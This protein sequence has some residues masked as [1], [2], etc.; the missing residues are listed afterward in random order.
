MTQ[1]LPTHTSGADAQI[2]VTSPGP[3]RT[4]WRLAPQ[5]LLWAAAVVAGALA[6]PQ[7]PWA[8][9]GLA[10]CLGLFIPFWKSS[11][12]VPPDVSRHQRPGDAARAAPTASNA[13][14]RQVLPVW[15]R[16][17]DSARLH[18]EQS[19][20]A[21]AESF[22]GIAGELD[23]AL[24][25]GGSPLR[26]D[27]RS[28]TQLLDTHR[29]EMD[30]LLAST[31]RIAALKNALA[32]GL[33][34]LS[35]PLSAMARLSKEVQTISRATHLLALNASVEAQ[36]VGA[37]GASGHG[38]A[39]VAQEVRALADQSRQAGAALDKH[40]AYLRDRVADLQQRGQRMDTG[41]D[42][43]QLQAEQAA[44]DVVGALLRSIDEV[45][46]SQRS[47]HDTGVQ[48]QREVEQILVNLQSQDRMSQMLVSVTD[49]MTR[50]QSWLEGHADEAAAA[51]SQ[52]L[53]RLE[54]SYT[55][56]DMRSSHHDTVRV[57]KAAE[58]E[59]F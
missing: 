33:G 54:A 53:E 58:V 18:A 25:D 15:R 7:G 3:R 40:L 10:L 23:R 44:R 30:T 1:S 35:E 43:L 37:A 34:D 9:A 19:I 57:D 52:W 2:G 38:F 29:P 56:E 16:N 12:R 50:M 41:E 11:T 31:Q 46:R 39:V 47:L 42:E 22:G 5:A 51:P 24:S 55:M 8:V 17:I 32:D 14:T 59:F 48:V 26:M 20:S 21:L 36:R 27:S 49:D 4:L 6:A 13:L 28:M 45:T